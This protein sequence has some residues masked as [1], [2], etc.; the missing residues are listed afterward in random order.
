[1]A[2]GLFGR[3]FAFNIKC[4]IFSLIIITLFFYKP[5]I[6][7]TY[8]AYG[9]SF[10]LFVVSYVAMAWYDSV[11]N[12]D[13]LPLKKGSVSAQRFLKPDAH[14]KEKQEKHLET[15]YETSLKYKLIYA[16][17]LFFIVP[18][19][20]YVAYYGKKT[21]NTGFIITGVLTAFTMAYHGVHLMYSMHNEDDA[22]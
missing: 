4:I 22:R 2:G 3:P 1:M 15:A 14:E 10:I 19:L 7:N 5:I 17:H 12:C 16:A 11:Y 13:I 9:T 8:V 20:G 6:K 18:L 21:P